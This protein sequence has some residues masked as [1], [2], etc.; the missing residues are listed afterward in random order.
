[1]RRLARSAHL[2]IGLALPVA[3]WISTRFIPINIGFGDEFDKGKIQ[4][5]EAGAFYAGPANHAHFVWTSEET[6]A[7]FTGIGPFDAQYV[8][9]ADDPRKSK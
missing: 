7:R 3:F 1:M 9:P 2:W 5:L 6:I 8:N 4:A